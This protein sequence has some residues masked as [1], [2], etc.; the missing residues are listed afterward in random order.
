MGN[1]D[2][3]ESVTLNAKHGGTKIGSV[4]NAVKDDIHYGFESESR[5]IRKR[6][7]MKQ[8]DLGRVLT[9]SSMETTL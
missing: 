6:K 7:T 5:T 9:S 2:N 1:D 8:K 4:S 3:D